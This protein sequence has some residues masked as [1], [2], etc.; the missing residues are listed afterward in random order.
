VLDAGAGEILRFAPT[1]N[2]FDSAPE[3]IVSG[4]DLERSSDFVVATDVFVLSQEGAVRRFAGGT[5]TEFGIAGLDPPLASPSTIALCREN[6]HLYIADG[7]HQRI[8]AI[9]QNGAFRQQLVGTQLT[10]I[11]AMALDGSGTVMVVAVGQ[12]LFSGAVPGLPG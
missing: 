4:A 2:G 12:S 5:E 7:G 10:T 1:S 9:G 8:V 6:G 3:R 11:N